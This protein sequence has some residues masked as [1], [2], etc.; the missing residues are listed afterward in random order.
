MIGR[1]S[2]RYGLAIAALLVATVPAFAAGGEGRYSDLTRCSDNSVSVDLQ[3]ASCTAALEGHMFQTK[4]QAVILL[5]DLGA[6]YM[7]KGDFDHAFPAFND[8]IRLEPNMWQPYENRGIAFMQFKQYDKALAD[9]TQV[10][11]LN[12]D[13]AKAYHNRG[14]AKQALGDK[15]GADADFAQAAALAPAVTTP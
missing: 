4:K 7:Q 10:I 1:N 12:P 9:F 14:V 3:I 5:Q 15:A 2:M 13:F 11:A 8:A 6:A